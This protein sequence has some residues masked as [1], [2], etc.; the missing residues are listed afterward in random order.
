MS[1]TVLNNP[2]FV[3]VIIFHCCSAA[4]WLKPPGGSKKKAKGWT[5]KFTW[6]YIRNN[7][8]KVVFLILYVLVNVGLTAYTVNKYIDSNAFVIGKPPWRT[9]SVAVVYVAWDKL[10]SLSSSLQWMLSC[11]DWLII[12]L[13][14]NVISMVSLVF[15]AFVLIFCSPS[16]STFWCKQNINIA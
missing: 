6:K 2:W 1:I 10:F 7:L 8:R 12:L 4:Q 15:I 14:L 13:V 9:R 3:H 11:V 16:T 5:E